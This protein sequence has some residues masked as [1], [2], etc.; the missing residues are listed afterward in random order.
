M[1][2]LFGMP[3]LVSEIVP[4][5]R[6]LTA[7]Q[8]RLEIAAGRISAHDA[9][10]EMIEAIQQDDPELHAWVA[11]KS[12]AE[13]EHPLGNATDVL[14]FPLFGIP[15]GVKDNIDT[16]EF[17]TEYGSEIYRLHRPKAD[18][19]CVSCLREA[20]AVILGKTASAEFAVR[21]PCATRNPL[22][23]AYTPG[24]SSS[25]SAAAI[26]AEMIP[27]SVGT[28]TGGSVIRPAAYCGV[29][30][31]KPSFGIVNRAG[32]KPNSDSVDTVGFFSRCLDDLALILGAVSRNR[33]LV[34]LAIKGLEPSAKDIRLAFCRS[35]QWDR[36][37]EE[38]QNVFCSVQDAAIAAGEA[39]E[40]DLTGVLEGLDL[41]SDIITEFETWQSL[42]FERLHY[43]EQCSDQL[44]EV[45]KRGEA[46]KFDDYVTARKKV[47]AG[48]SLFDDL[49]G[50]FDCLVTLS[51]PGEAPFGL[52][53]TG[54]STFNK[55]W[56]ALHVPCVNVPAGRGLHGLPFGL[57]VISARYRDDTALIGACK[58]QSLLRQ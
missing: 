11:V 50:E 47:E 49:F 51:A 48:R 32:V 17:N 16:K 10:T 12:N 41:A 21:R 13:L 34:Q 44:V 58:L 14:R 6:K 8:L 39:V 27:L 19:A 38:L 53:D 2:R 9:A 37:S 23:H 35:P 15:I 4:T 7:K 56:S 31:I 25:G 20:G 3:V 54:P 40:V 57:Q 5:A 28:Q 45:L 29:N 46:H 18:A 24:G 52:A 33:A 26:A 42:G 55:V 1:L 43:G 22:N 36:A 30:A